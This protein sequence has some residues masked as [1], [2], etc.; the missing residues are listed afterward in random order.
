MSNLPIVKD[1]FHED[2]NTF[3][4]V[5]RDPATKACA[6]ID[7]VLDYDPASASTS[8]IHADKIIAYIKEQGLTVEWILETHVHADHLTAAQ[9][10]KAEL[11]GKIAMSQK[12]S[13]VQE[14]FGAIY[15][16]DIKQWNAQ[17]LFDYLFED[18]ESF[19]IGTLKAYNIPTPGHTPACLSYV[20]GDAVF[21][22]DTLFMPDYGT[23]RCDFPRGS[24]EQ[25]YDSV[26]S[27]FQLPEDT[28]V[29][30]CHD[31][32]P[33]TRESYVCES[34]IQTQKTQNI[35]IHQGIS[36]AEFAQMRNQRDSGLGMP[37]LILPAIQINMKAGQFPEP[38][39]NGV[40]YLKLPLNYFK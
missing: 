14:T 2:T 28:R 34:D 4:Y 13:V 18:H 17:Q 8:T 37:K 15:H 1:F 35:H 24:A 22:G 30:L 40:S 16:L 23:A 6:I 27:L 39:A 32:L 26:Q 11:G 20:I 38:E 12:I 3:S 9:Y 7:S 19:Q 33:E 31:Y 36:K 21:V 5:V 10:L 29:F 25:L